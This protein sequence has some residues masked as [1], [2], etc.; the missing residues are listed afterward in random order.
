MIVDYAFPGTII[1]LKTLFKVAIEQE[2]KGVDCFKAFL[3]LPVDI[4]FLSFSFGAAILYTEQAS[5]HHSTSV[6]G[7]MIFAIGCTV[8]ALVVSVLSKKADKA[9][10]G[11]K[12]FSSLV[13]AFFSY[14]ISLGILISS[15]MVAEI[16]KYV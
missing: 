7:I 16:A 1:I 8:F 4:A 2:V 10:T 15:L 13:L 11:D 12:T 5:G 6:R 3:A 9:F 14:S